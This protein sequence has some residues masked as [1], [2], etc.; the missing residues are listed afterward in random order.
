[1]GGLARFVSLVETGLKT[2]IPPGI[3]YLNVSTFVSLLDKF[4][5]KIDGLSESY[6]PDRQSAKD[7]TI[8]Y[9]PQRM[10]IQS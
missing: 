4:P 1:M 7:A 3:L 9:I 6:C 5:N 2:K 8:V 10:R